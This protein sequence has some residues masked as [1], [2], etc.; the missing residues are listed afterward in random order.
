MR[1]HPGHATVTIFIL[2]NQLV[3]ADDLSRVFVYAQRETPARSWTPVGCDGE[4][5]AEVK[6]GFFF[7]VTLRPGRHLLSLEGGVP[8][9]ID[10]RS[11][12]ETFVRVD[13]NYD[14]RRPPIPVLS[15][16]DEE[17]A[18]TEMRFL[19][20]VE[21]KRIHSLAISKTDPRPTVSPQ[22]KTTRPE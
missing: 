8:I 14:V 1:L 5:I 13:W 12:V 15:S 4:N 16:V 11:G 9:S 19:S 3:A 21:T 10:V 20:Y 7:S 6:R 17:R 2:C 18:K 22:L